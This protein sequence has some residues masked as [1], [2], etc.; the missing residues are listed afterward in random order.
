MNHPPQPAFEFRSQTS[1]GQIEVFIILL[2]GD[3]QK[4]P[5]WGRF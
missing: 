3:N 5:G 2:F 4:R 1:A